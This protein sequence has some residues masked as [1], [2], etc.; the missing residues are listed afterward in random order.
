MFGAGGVVEETDGQEMKQESSR[1]YSDTVVFQELISQCVV[2]GKHVWI[3]MTC[4]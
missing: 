3:M 2:R 4:A 1:E